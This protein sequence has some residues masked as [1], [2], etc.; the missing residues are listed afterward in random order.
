M[1]WGEAFTTGALVT[2]MVVWKPEWIA[3]FSD[4]RYLAPR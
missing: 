1:A 4:Q 2:L 3:T